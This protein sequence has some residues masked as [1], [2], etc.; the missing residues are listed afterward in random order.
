MNYNRPELLD[1]LAAEYV[2]G[3]LRGRALGRFE[4]LVRE[5]PAARAAVQAWEQRLAT[6]ATSVPPD[7]S[8]ARSTSLRRPSS[9]AARTDASRGS[10]IAARNT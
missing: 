1:R 10:R 4:R 7:W 8:R 9:A 3:T 6:L 2:L 5:L